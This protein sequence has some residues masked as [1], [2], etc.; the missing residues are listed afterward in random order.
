[1]IV[2]KSAETIQGEKLFKGGNYSR[3]YGM[4]ACEQKPHSTCGGVKSSQFFK[5]EVP[6]D[7]IGKLEPDIIYRTSWHVKFEKLSPSW[8]T[9]SF[10]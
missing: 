5:F 1:M 9:K 4:L 3:K 2:H 8:N 7:S 10:I 6:T